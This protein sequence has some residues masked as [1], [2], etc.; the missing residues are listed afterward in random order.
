[1]TGA[2]PG[3][4]QDGQSLLPLRDQNPALEVDPADPVRDR[5]RRERPSSPGPPRPP[6]SARRTVKFSTYV[7]NPDLDHTA[8]FARAI[9]APRYRASGPA[10]TC[11]SST[12][13]AAARCTTSPATRSS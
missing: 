1:M 13:T 6:P 5:A 11:W 9:V 2:K 8:Q 12:P 7:K 3:L 4:P 10:A